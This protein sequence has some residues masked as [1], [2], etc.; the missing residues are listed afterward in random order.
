LN[1]KSADIQNVLILNLPNFGW[2]Y[3]SH[4]EMCGGIGFK[5]LRHHTP[6]QD[7]SHH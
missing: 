6:Q 7:I 2:R 1:I 3:Q 4:K 5:T